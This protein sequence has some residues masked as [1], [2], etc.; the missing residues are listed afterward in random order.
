MSKEKKFKHVLTPASPELQASTNMY[1][2]AFRVMNWVI[3][4]DES[5]DSLSPDVNRGVKVNER[6]PTPEEMKKLK[7]Q[8]GAYHNQDLMA[9]FKKCVDATT[10]QYGFYST[11]TDY[12]ANIVVEGE[13]ISCV[14]ENNFLPIFDPTSAPDLFWTFIPGQIE[15]VFK[16]NEEGMKLESYSLSNDVLYNLSLGNI[17]DLSKEKLKQLAE[18]AKKQESPASLYKFYK[19]QAEFLLGIDFKNFFGGINKYSIRYFEEFFFECHHFLSHNPELQEKFSKDEVFSKNLEEIGKLLK[20]KPRNNIVTIA[21]NGGDGRRGNPQAEKI[22]IFDKDKINSR[23]EEIENPAEKL[24]FLEH[25]FQVIKDNKNNLYTHAGV[26]GRGLTG[27]Q[28]RHIGI[29]KELYIDVVKNNK[30]NEAILEALQKKN[31]LVDFN[32]SNTP[33]LLKFKKTATRKK[34]EEILQRYSTPETTPLLADTDKDKEVQ[35]QTFPTTPQPPEPPFSPELVAQWKKII[36]FIKNHKPKESMVPFIGLIADF[37]P[38][39]KEYI[40]GIGKDAITEVIDRLSI[41]VGNVKLSETEAKQYHL[42]MLGLNNFQ[43]DLGSKISDKMNN[44]V[45]EL[46]TLGGDIIFFAITLKSNKTHGELQRKI[47]D[48]EADHKTVA[49]YFCKQSSIEDVVKYILEYPERIEFLMEVRPSLKG[50]LKDRPDLE[51]KLFEAALNVKG[52][53][54]NVI[55]QF[56]PNLKTLDQPPSL[57]LKEEIKDY[58]QEIQQQ[59]QLRDE[60]KKACLEAVE[61][62]TNEA[63]RNLMEKRIEEIIKQNPPLELPNEYQIKLFVDEI[64]QRLNSSKGFNKRDYFSLCLKFSMGKEIGKDFFTAISNNKH[65]IDSKVY[66]DDNYKQELPQ[67]IQAGRTVLEVETPVT[68]VSTLSK[69]TH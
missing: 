66:R 50:E 65:F 43:Y 9:F 49:E 1:I 63:L 56:L 7:S 41:E 68:T 5:Q 51:E 19:K 13:N 11:N 8:Y 12:E 47:S 37:I 58:S 44:H 18:E 4:K 57:T 10:S 6:K 32:R 39:C 16:K 3:G 42:V 67:K 22:E 45:A 24:E 14:T 53:N 62:I 17:K 55:M 20:E 38:K 48:I 30:G 60:S 69:V 59:Q 34:I 46:F 21:Q 15:V 25:F 40:K 33:D 64:N 61:K 36:D 2:A 27:T 28:Q 35:L 31:G 23:L 26:I 54:F 52:I 29:L